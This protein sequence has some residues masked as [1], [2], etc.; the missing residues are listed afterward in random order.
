MCIFFN[1]INITFMLA[2]MNLF[3]S[4]CSHMLNKHTIN[5]TPGNFSIHTIFTEMLVL[6]FFFHNFDINSTNDRETVCP[7]GTEHNNNM[8]KRYTMYNML[9]KK[10]SAQSIRGI[11]YVSFFFEVDFSWV[12]LFY[13]FFFDFGILLKSLEFIKIKKIR[14]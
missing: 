12:L 5:H 4:S 13:V 11:Q 9:K 1:I 8:K 3:L 7:F 10:Q 14:I 2:F 6:D